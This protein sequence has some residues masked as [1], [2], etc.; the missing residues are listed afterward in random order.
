MVD[1]IR[2]NW[3]YLVGMNIRKANLLCLGKHEN[4][5]K[6][7]DIGQQDIFSAQLRDFIEKNKEISVL[8]AFPLFLYDYFKPELF[9]LN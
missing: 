4:P 3:I 5:C 9:R 7:E 8:N 2:M 6:K 1:R